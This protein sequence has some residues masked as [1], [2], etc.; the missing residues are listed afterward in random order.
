MA[1]SMSVR[2]ESI[3][4]TKSARVLDQ[5]QRPLRDLR[6]SVTDRCNFRC[7]YCMPAASFSD[8]K[9][10]LPSAELLSFDEIARVVTVAVQ[11]LGVRKLRITGGEPLLRPDLPALIARLRRLHALD[12]ITLTTNGYLLAE[13]AAALRAAGLSRITVSLDSLDPDEFGR[14]SGRVRG[15]ARVLA[16]IEAACEVGLGPLKLNCVVVRGQ[17]EAAIIALCERFRG[18]PHIVRF[19][20]YMDVGTQNAWRAQDVVTADEIIARVQQRWPLHAL[21]PNY[22]GEVAKRYRYADGQGEI[23]VIA[24]VS[25]P[26]CGLCHRARV[27]ADGRLLTCLF[28]ATGTHLKPALRSR[29][30]TDTDTTDTALRTLLRDTW[31]ARSDRYSQER[32]NLGPGRA[33]RRLEMYQVGG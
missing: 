21:P 27:S 14:M 3:H 26:F 13:H 33:R 28:A 19:I 20:E 8:A 23:G 4:A 18:T 24:S 10:F 2:T 15:L 29:L 30:D 5:L 17:N 32:A 11:E 31:R 1:I 22:P 25:E 16:G 7:D 12:E 6:V 9:R